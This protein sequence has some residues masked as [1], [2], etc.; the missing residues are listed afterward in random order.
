[1]ADPEFRKFIYF[2]NDYIY[3]KPQVIYVADVWGTSWR[4]SALLRDVEEGRFAFFPMVRCQPY[5]EE[6]WTACMQW[7]ARRDL[8]ESEYRDLMKRGVRTDDQQ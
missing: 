3:K 5:S 6:L 8:L 4:G 7:L 1:M 2:P